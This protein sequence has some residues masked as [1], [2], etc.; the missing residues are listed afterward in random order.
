MLKGK[1][2]T[3]FSFKIDEDVKDDYDLLQAFNLIDAGHTEKID[4]AVELMLGKEQKDKL[5]EHCRGKS[6][7]VLAS[8]IV[9]EVTEIINIIGQSESD[10]KN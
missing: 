6:G 7:R 2:S 4:E 9:N 1:T 3:G 5:R 8:K 10:V